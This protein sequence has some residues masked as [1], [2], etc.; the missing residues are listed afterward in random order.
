M[1]GV[2]H[3]EIAE[4][5]EELKQLLRQSKS[6]SDKE[7]IQFLYLLKSEQASTMSQA[8]SLLGRNRVTI[9]KWA[10]RYREGGLAMMLSHTP[11][12]GAPHKI[13]AWAQSALKNRLQQ[14][15]GF[16]SYGAICQWLEESL[17]IVAPYKSVHRLVHDRLKASPK[18]V[19]PQ[20]DKQDEERLMAYKKTR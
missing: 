14:E 10:R 7:R 15:D 5:S 9:Q 4:S 1:A 12:T 6:A 3:L 2:Y 8:A 18:V 16:E 20:S 13:P 19:R 11:R 17:G